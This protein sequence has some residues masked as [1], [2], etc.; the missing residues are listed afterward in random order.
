MSGGIDYNEA[1][2]NRIETVYKTPDVA[3]QRQAVLDTLQPQPGERV[4]DI[5]SGPGMLVAGIARKVGRTGCVAGVDIS[6][7]M[8]ELAAART[9]DMPWVSIREGNATELPFFEGEFDAAV[10][11]Q[12]YEY[13]EDIEKALSELFRVL[14]PGGRAVILDT[15]WDTL[16]WNTSDRQRLNRIMELFAPHCAHPHLARQLPSL[17]RR[18]GFFLVDCRV[19]T[20][21]NTEYD[22]NTYSYG[23][24]KFIGS[25]VGENGRMNPA[26]VKAWAD[27]LADLGDAGAY[28]F[29]NNR[30]IFTV[31][32]KV[33]GQQ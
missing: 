2:A 18:A 22:P 24:I 33:S 15:D 14:K 19:H 25:Y 28:F 7:A 10:S 21:L 23:L 13:V 12:V 16:I 32:N 30:Y 31:S 27:E 1:W 20:I 8:N 17:L 3:A 11:T 26:E 6:D 29:S 5:G 4:L 9:A